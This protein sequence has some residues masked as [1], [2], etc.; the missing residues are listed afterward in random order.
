M[1]INI[2]LLFLILVIFSC[3]PALQ[4]KEIENYTLN[5]YNQ[6]FSNYVRQ[7]DS[8]INRES[9]LDNLRIKSANAQRYSDIY[10]AIK[11]SLEILQD[12][13]IEF[14]EPGEIGSNRDIYGFG[15]LTVLYE[16]VIIRIFPR[17]NAEITGLKVGDIITSI[18]GKKIGINESLILPDSN[19]LHI[20]I[21]RKSINQF[22]SYLVT[23]SIFSI[24]VKPKANTIQNK[25]GYL[26]IPSYLG[27]DKNSGFDDDSYSQ[28]VQKKIRKLDEN[29]DL[30]GWVIDFRRNTGG[31][32]NPMLEGLKP[33]LLDGLENITVGQEYFPIKNS[34]NEFFPRDIVLR[35]SYYHV[36]TPY[37]PVAILQSRMT[38]SSG[39]ITTIAFIGRNSTRFFGENTN[40]IP[41][42]RSDF[43]LLDGAIIALPVAFMADR[44]GWI[45]NAP[46]NPDREV[47]MDWTLI[48]N[49]TKDPVL[50]A[51]LKWLHLNPSC[52]K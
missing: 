37:L 52:L 25:I 4:Y 27:E 15:F 20:I 36:K 24:N 12:P 45:Y 5:I 10:P 33:I 6:L 22:F 8:E 7:N 50:N 30:C 18:N 41:T 2:R 19:I 1:K 11:S 32:F 42:L 23:K 35:G 47:K 43:S 17:S 9:F 46:I 44:T 31:N 26:E 40:G 48:E 3:V 34:K 39:E 49:Q 16:N 28:F 38:A 21:Y 13:H 29:Q 14:F 51:A